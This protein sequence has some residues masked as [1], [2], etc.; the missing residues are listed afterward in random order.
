MV[1]YITVSEKQLYYLKQLEKKERIKITETN[2]SILRSLA[3]KFPN[4][5]QFENNGNVR[6]VSKIR[7]YI[8]K[9]IKKYNGKYSKVGID[10]IQ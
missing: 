1:V 10:V 2:E 8:I 4:L 5:F 6:F 9:E 3:R 7:E